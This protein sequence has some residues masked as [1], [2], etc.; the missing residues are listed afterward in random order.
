[1]GAFSLPVQ[2]FGALHPHVRFVSTNL[3]AS[4]F[5]QGGFPKVQLLL[6]TPFLPS[7]TKMG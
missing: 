3:I 4:T 2:A 5:V 6:E 7:N 1:V